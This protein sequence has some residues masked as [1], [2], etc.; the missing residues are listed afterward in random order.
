VAWQVV[1]TPPAGRAVI[2]LDDSSVVTLGPATTL[3]YALSR[4]RRDV[5]LDGLADFKV[6]HDTR[7]PFVVRARNAQTS[8]LGTE[9]VVRAYQ[10]DSLTTVSVSSGAVRVSGADSAGGLTLHAGD[11]ATVD[12]GGLAATAPSRTASGASL[13]MRGGLAFSNRP[14]DEVAEELGRWFDVDVRVGDSVLAHKRITATYASPSLDGVLA[15]IAATT[16][17]RFERSGRTITWRR[18]VR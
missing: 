4:S 5:M 1:R 12:R 11:V 9:F 3:R 14:L 16:G 13:W 2:R 7:R 8:D 18:G 10:S 6:T 15:S 17:A